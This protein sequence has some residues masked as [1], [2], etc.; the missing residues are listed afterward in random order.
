[1]KNLI[2]SLVML[3]S[4]F[5]S[6]SQV[7]EVEFDEYIG[8]NSGSLG[9]YEEVI[10]STNYKVSEFHNGGGVNKYIINLTTNTVDHYFN[11]TLFKSGKI[12]TSKIDGGL[13]YI[14]LN[15]K[16]SVSGNVI[17]SN[18]VVPTDKS[19]NNN[20]KFIIYFF[21]TSTNTFNGFVAMK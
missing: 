2:L 14:T 20:P 15:D 12:L 13:L 16:E 4:S 18:I 7:I 10:D 17:T 19:N 8:F 1:M 5:V 11:G 9:K 21:S 3:V 6:F